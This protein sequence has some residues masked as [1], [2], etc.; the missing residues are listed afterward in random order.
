M[1]AASALA[2]DTA[3]VKPASKAEKAITAKS[4][5]LVPQVQGKARCEVEMPPR[6][7]KRELEALPQDGTHRPKLLLLKGKHRCRP[8]PQINLK[9][10][11]Y[12]PCWS[13]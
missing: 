1:G 8:S 4:K 2:E 10:G 11:E 9:K 6:E 12:K 5:V 13:L 3:S 7:A